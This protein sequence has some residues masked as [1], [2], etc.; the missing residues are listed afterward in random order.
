[1]TKFSPALSHQVIVMATS[2]DLGDGLFH[3]LSATGAL[4]LGLEIREVSENRIG[5][6]ET[7]LATFFGG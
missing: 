7:D 1:M 5:V 3:D 6:A 2:D 4:G